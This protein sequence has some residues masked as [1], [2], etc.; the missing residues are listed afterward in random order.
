MFVLP[1]EYNL[2]KFTVCLGDVNLED[3]LG[4]CAYFPSMDVI[5]QR[6]LTLFVLRLSSKETRSSIVRCVGEATLA[7]GALDVILFIKSR[8]S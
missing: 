4:S 1:A 8:Y 3:N 5:M 6:S 2:D 7:R